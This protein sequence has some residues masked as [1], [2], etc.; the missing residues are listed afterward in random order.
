MSSI[1]P[2]R[3]CLPWTAL[4][5]GDH[6][7]F[8]AGSSQMKSFATWWL[9]CLAPG[10]A[11]AR[12]CYCSWLVG[13]WVLSRLLVLLVLRA[14]SWYCAPSVVLRGGRSCCP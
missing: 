4:L 2:R 5:P 11:G 13:W 1:C 12:A 3:E 8:A 14:I 6:G 10:S 9:T 7:V